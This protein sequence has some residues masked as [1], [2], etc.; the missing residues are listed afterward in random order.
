MCEECSSFH[1][2]IYL[3]I[4]PEEKTVVV[5]GIFSTNRERDIILNV[6]YDKLN[7]KICKYIDEKGEG[8]DCV[9]LRMRSNLTLFGYKIK[10]KSE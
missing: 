1:P 2:P 6:D 8:P 7:D 9:I 3:E 10:I 4:E 5:D